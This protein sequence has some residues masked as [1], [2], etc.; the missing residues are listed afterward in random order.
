M[1][2]VAA[3]LV[4]RPQNAVFA[5]A[6]T[7]LLP[8]LATL[9]GAILVLLVL[10][11]D[12]RGAIV[13]MAFASLVVVVVAFVSGSSPL[14]TSIG[15]AFFWLP[16]LVL[17]AIMRSTRSL[18][19]TLQLSVI[20]VLAGICAFFALINDPVGF[21]QATIES[22]PILQGLQ[23]QEWKNAVGANAE[24]FAGMMTT[25]FAIGFWFGLVIV[26]LLGYWV[27]QQLPNKT[28]EFGRFC[29]LN[30]GRVIAF[31]LVVTSV[32]GFAINA[33]WIQSIAFVMFAVFWLQ[34][35]AM[36]HWLHSSGFVPVIAV[37]AV[38]ALTIVLLEYMFP[39]LAVLG[40]TDAWFRYRRRARKQ[41]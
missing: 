6:I 8:G 23:L 33:I 19:L 29:D 38:Y 10:Q 4:A 26:V 1:Q 11:Q 40:Y 12:L 22:T 35:A 17:A 39:A 25:M 24:Q 31:L 9:S 27:Y 36:V 34:G 7:M 2:S 5:L 14:L 20:V 30:F 3:W 41:Q 18:A 13:A 28:A 37:F 21:W 16:I 15:L 32:V